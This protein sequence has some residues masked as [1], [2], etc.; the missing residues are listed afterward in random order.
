[1]SIRQA[2]KGQLFSL[3][4]ST[5]KC[6]ELRNLGQRLSVDR[7]SDM[8]GRLKSN[9]AT[10]DEIKQELIELGA[11]VK[12]EPVEVKPKQDWQAIYDEAHA[13]GMAAGKAIVPVPMNVVAHAN[14]L[15]DTSPV[16]QSWHVSEGSCGFAWISFKG[17]TSWGKWTIAQ[18]LASKDYPS[19]Y[20]IWVSEFGQSIERKYKYAC[21]FAEVLRKHGIKCNPNCRDD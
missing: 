3:F 21:A 20:Q 7:A 16:V 18:K 11:D 13:A 4:L 6:L 5:G 17:N 8:I 1:M 10:A 14:V 15:D 2:S 9:D 12:G 19:G